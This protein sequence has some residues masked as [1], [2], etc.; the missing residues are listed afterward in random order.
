MHVLACRER[1]LTPVAKAEYQRVPTRF[2]FPRPLG[3]VEKGMK[4]VRKRVQREDVLGGSLTRRY[5]VKIR[6]EAEAG[7]SPGGVKEASV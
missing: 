3:S 4:R 7:K 2:F 1:R 6:G 5:F